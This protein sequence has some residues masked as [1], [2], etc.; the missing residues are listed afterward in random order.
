VEARSRISLTGVGGTRLAK[1]EL[2]ERDRELRRRAMGIDA[3]KF[4]RDFEEAAADET[5]R[6][7]L[8]KL[9]KW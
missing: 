5:L 1:A 8:V 6:D 9:H 4:E 2:K 7:F 3:V